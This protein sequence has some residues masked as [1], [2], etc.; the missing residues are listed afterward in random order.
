MR[1]V[2]LIGVVI[3]CAEGMAQGYSDAAQTAFAG[4]DVVNVRNGFQDINPA[5]IAQIE[6]SK[7]GFSQSRPFLIQELPYNSIFFATKH[8]NNFIG[9]DFKH[10]NFDQYLHQ[11]LKFLYAK[12]LSDRLNLGIIT[13]LNHQRYESL[14][15]YEFELGFGIHYKYKK[16]VDFGSIIK[17]RN[18]QDFIIKTGLAYTKSKKL[19]IY[20]SLELSPNERYKFSTAFEYRISEKLQARLGLSSDENYFSFG[21]LYRIKKLEIEVAT[22][23]HKYLGQSPCITISYE[24]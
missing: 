5:T 20:L 6:K 9:L 10:F 21:F 14:H 16:H 2:G 17:R 24:F 8:K 12:K 22:A 13:G 23:L 18:K 3:C 19:P 1:W 11:N 4:A 15:R 7:I